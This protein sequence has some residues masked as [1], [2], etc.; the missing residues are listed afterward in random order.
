[1]NYLLILIWLVV[2]AGIFVQ[3]LV[4]RKTMENGYFVDAQDGGAFEASNALEKVSD[5]RIIP[6]SNLESGTN[7]SKIVLN[8]DGKNW[9]SSVGHGYTV[10]S[11]KP[12]VFDIVFD[13]VLQDVDGLS[14]SIMYS[15]FVNK[16]E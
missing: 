13:N 5:L 1:M 16:V 8:V 11:S 6:S 4:M 9:T 3:Q 2:P 7:G 15:N 12:G 14:V 10:S